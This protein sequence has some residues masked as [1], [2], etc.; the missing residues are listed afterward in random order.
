MMARVVPGTKQMMKLLPPALL[1]LLVFTSIL[2]LSLYNH[3]LLRTFM[4]TSSTIHGPHSLFDPESIPFFYNI[5]APTSNDTNVMAIIEEQLEILKS[6]NQSV[7]VYYNTIGAE[8]VDTARVDRLCHSIGL[9]KCRHLQ[10]YRSA[11]EEVTLQALHDYCQ[12]HDGLVGYIH[13]K[14]TY[15]AVS[16]NGLTQDTWR[17]H[18]TMATVHNDCLSLPDQCHVCGLQA[19]ISPFTHIP[20]NFFTADCGYVRRLLPLKVFR[21][22]LE[23]ALMERQ[24]W[25]EQ[26]YFVSTRFEY[27]V[28]TLGY[29]RYANEHWIL[30]RPEV[31]PCVLSDG[32]TVRW[33]KEGGNTSTW[34]RQLVPLQPRLDPG[35]ALTR[36]RTQ[37]LREYSLLP[38]FLFQWIRIYERV[39]PANSWVW[40]WFPDG[41]AW[42]AALDQY[43]FEAVEYLTGKLNGT[44][45]L[46]GDNT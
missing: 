6:A 32:S 13:T 11:F 4:P 45:K 42:R 16:W 25:V 14:G 30:S 23:S 31:Q 44:V 37:R 20:G 7:S 3:L 29:G 8:P 17:R 27:A 15:H 19:I 24:D 35:R 9:T 43:G 39:P 5:Y 18:L 1:S 34:H 40:Q 22:R 26:D 12:Y 10:H 46:E 33:Q 21:A 38:G 41:D 36:N 2:L 28:S